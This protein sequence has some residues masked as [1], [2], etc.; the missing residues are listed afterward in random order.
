MLNRSKGWPQVQFKIEKAQYEVAVSDTGWMYGNGVVLPTSG[1][2]FNN[3][4]QNAAHAAAISANVIKYYFKRIKD[5]RGVAVTEE[6]TLWTDTSYPKNAGTYEVIVKVGST[7]N[8]AAPPVASS[9]FVIG[10]ASLDT[11]NT[12]VMKESTTAPYG[13]ATWIAPGVIYESGITDT[14]NAGYNPGSDQL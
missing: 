1:P 13:L 8:Y 9:E 7:T 10:K 3:T 14:T 2:K 11:P 4:A 5:S 6:E 12:L